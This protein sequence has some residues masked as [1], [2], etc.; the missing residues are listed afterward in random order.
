MGMVRPP[1]CG[2]GGSGDPPPPLGVFK[3]SYQTLPY[4]SPSSQSG[5]GRPRPNFSNKNIMAA[6]KNLCHLRRQISLATAPWHQC[7]AFFATEGIKLMKGKICD[8]DKYQCREG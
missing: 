8:D 7:F 2:W 6:K 5:L 1:T 3:H 4:P